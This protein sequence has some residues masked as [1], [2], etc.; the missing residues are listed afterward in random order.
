MNGTEEPVELSP[1]PDRP[2][3]T[4]LRFALLRLLGAV[5]LAAFYSLAIQVLPL[6][7]EHG[8]QP[9]SLFVARIAERSSR[10]QGFLTLPSLFF[11]G[12]SDTLLL[13][14]SYLGV[15][16]SL[17]VLCGYANALILFVLW[18]LY[19]SFV[20]IGQIFYGYGW[21]ILLCEAGFLAIFLCPLLDGR[22]FPRRAVPRP[23]IW[24]FRWLALRIMLGAGL[25]KL[26]GDVCW[27]DLTCLDYHFETQPIPNPLS[28]WFHFLPGFM[29]KLGVVGN[30]LCELVMPL[31][32]FGPRKLRIIAG[33]SMIA[34]Q[35]VLI[36]SGNLSFLNW[37]T[38]VPLLACLDDKFL[39]RRL[40]RRLVRAAANADAHAVPSRATPF[41]VWTLFGLVCLLSI[42]PTVNLFS[43]QQR[44]NGSFDPFNLVNTYGAFG[45]VGRERDEIILEGTSDA[46]PD[47]SARWIAYEF[48]CKPGDVTR[49]PCLM[50]PLQYRLDW[51]I[52][53]AAMSDLA[54][55]PW[56]V[57]LVY[58]LLHNDKGA[59]KLLANNPF[60]D[61]PPRYIRA[62]LYRY[63]LTPRRE[64]AYWRR[65]RLGAYMPPLAADDERLRSYLQ[66]M[67]WLAEKK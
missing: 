24:L 49:R 35:L 32:V 64:R 8:L 10:W 12:I 27:R 59:L 39:Q 26:R 2:P 53:F 66:E 52:W 46:T 13:D 37:L 17:L 57:H 62:E 65:E 51:Q 44:M 4:L 18:A 31:F 34:F 19:L 63:K 28:A 58:K 56:L 1:P 67:G 41:V 21:E 25:I 60:P 11:A 43:P 61:A 5:Y 23:V 55:E 50:S 20:H 42:S 29:H 33:L 40:P 15:A 54:S 30:H 7:G 48:P 9:A 3:Y 45:S 47:A 22:P 6:L 16:L 36:A 38:I 14:L